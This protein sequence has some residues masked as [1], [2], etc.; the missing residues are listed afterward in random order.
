MRE[1]DSIV[2]LLFQ[3]VEPGSI[4]SQ[5]PIAAVTVDPDHLIPDKDRTNNVL[6]VGAGGA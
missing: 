1:H 3:A 6:T 4:D 2:S 5:Q